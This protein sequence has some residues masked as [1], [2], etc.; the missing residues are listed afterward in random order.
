[1]PSRGAPGGLR[2]PLPSLP[3][4]SCEM[5]TS[6]LDKHTHNRNS[7]P[8]PA[9]F[10]SKDRWVQYLRAAGLKVRAYPEDTEGPGADLS[11]VEFA[12][13]WNPP[14]GLLSRVRR[15]PSLQPCMPPAH[16]RLRGRC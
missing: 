13:C 1:M 16:G 15:T 2:H 8:L 10:P 12:I 3:C 5:A 6:V 14:P 11:A 9:D 7:G 4:D